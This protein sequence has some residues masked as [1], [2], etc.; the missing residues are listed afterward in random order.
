MIKQQRIA[1]V[2]V[3]PRDEAQIRI[4]PTK[5]GA[6][7]RVC[8]TVR[9]WGSCILFEDGHKIV[10]GGNSSKKMAVRRADEMIALRAAI[11]R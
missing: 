6:D 1:G 7:G 4:A 5:L 3:I 9:D 2:N 11:A 8:R 10:E